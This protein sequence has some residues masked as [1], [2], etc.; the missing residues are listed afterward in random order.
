MIK[1][2]GKQFDPN[3]G[4]IYFIVAA[5][6]V[7]T[8]AGMYA[9]PYL[10]VAVNELHND[11]Q[12]REVRRFTRL[13]IKVMLD[14]GVFWLA[15][16]HAV[17]HSI[18]LDEAINLAPEDLD[19]FD[20]LRAH[21]LRVVKQIG[22]ISWGYVEIDQGGR[23]NKIRTRQG[24]EKLGLRP[25]PV[26]HPLGDGWDYF[27]D[28]ASRYDRICIGN[29]VHAEYEIRL[30]LFAT[31][32]ERRRKYPNLWIHLLG[33]TPNELM[34][35]F[36]MN[37]MDSSTW[38][39]SQRWPKSPDDYADGRTFGPTF[40]DFQYE[41]GREKEIHTAHYSKARQMEAYIAEFQQRNLRAHLEALCGEFESK[42]LYPAGGK[43]YGPAKGK[44]AHV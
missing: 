40:P 44:S 27:D 41:L 18:S 11:E 34:N 13:G 10:L 33:V 7:Y 35:A 21:Y 26:Y 5:T 19:G 16:E 3:E 8:Q 42:T 20:A 29:T 9:H 23:A 37:S 38:L 32:W 43:Q 2:A 36:P 12:I 22:E 28:L 30:R 24:L 1:T 25:I 6:G 31:L 14:S 15:N 4:T 39:G 17:K